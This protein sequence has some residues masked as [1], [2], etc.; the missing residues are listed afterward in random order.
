MGLFCKWFS[1]ASNM[2]M[3]KVM[4]ITVNITALMENLFFPPFLLV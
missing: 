3:L 4:K 2:L 1:N